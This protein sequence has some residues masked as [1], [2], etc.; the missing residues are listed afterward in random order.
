MRR[1][2]GYK[3]ERRRKEDIY[4]DNARKVGRGKNKGRG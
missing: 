3:K 4:T 2:L 1:W